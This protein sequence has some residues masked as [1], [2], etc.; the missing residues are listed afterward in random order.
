MLTGGCFCGHVRY[1]AEGEPFHET[2]CHCS[3]CR[4][5]VGAA[6][7]AWFSVKRGDLRF[8]SGAP[9]M[10]KSSAKVT[11]SF[12]GVCGT[13]LT[14]AD[15]DHPLEIDITICSLDDANRL[16]PKDH[17]EAAGKLRWVRVDD[18]LPIYRERRDIAIAQS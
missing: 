13:S 1:E 11:R 9:T 5:V 7:V 14:F 16:P 17:S 3:F 6:P 4:R 18:G 15:E 10:F 12:C 2:L 8:T